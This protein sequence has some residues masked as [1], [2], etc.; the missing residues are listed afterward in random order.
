MGTN[1][2]PVPRR[3]QAAALALWRWRAPLFAFEPDAEWGLDRSALESLFRLAAAAPGERTDQAYRH[4]VT[5]LRTAPLFTSEVDP[6]TVQL[7]QLETV[8]NL[9]T[10]AEL[11]DNPGGDE[12]DRVH[13][14]SAGLAG[15]LDALVED[16]LHA[17]PSEEAHRAY[18]TALTDPA[19]G[20]Y[21]ASRHAAVE[22]A[23]HRALDSLPDSTG[24]TGSP[25]G[26][27]LLALCED[28]GAELVTTLHWLRTTG[29]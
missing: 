3:R 13:E 21:F 29:Y 27:G 15:H 17:H 20:G 5:A 23:C 12:A 11:L 28:F 10:F 26:R 18:V 4:A 8:G 24:L 1:P 7:V 14:T 9:L 16:S 19:H 25:A 6:D 2:K 22:T